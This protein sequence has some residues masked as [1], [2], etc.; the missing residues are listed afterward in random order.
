ML[1]KASDTEKCRLMREIIMGNLKY[2]ENTDENNRNDA[3]RD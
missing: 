1:L 2:E 3:Y